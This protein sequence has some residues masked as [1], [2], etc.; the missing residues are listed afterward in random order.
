MALDVYKRQHWGMIGSAAFNGVSE[1]NSNVSEAV[2]TFLYN[3]ILMKM[4]GQEGV[5]AITI[6]LYA[7]LLYT[8]RCV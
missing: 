7:C 1:M 2:V 4:V 5:A 3:I 6:V 8:S